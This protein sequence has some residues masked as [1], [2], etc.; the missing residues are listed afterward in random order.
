MSEKTTIVEAGRVALENLGRAATISEIYAKIVELGLYE[1]NTPEPKYVL[2]TQIPESHSRYRSARGG[3]T[4][5]V[6]AGGGLA[7]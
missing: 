6:R 7:L 2:R 5:S 3:E 1:F 4:K